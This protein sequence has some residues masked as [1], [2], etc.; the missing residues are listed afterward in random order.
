[1]PQ[2]KYTSDSTDSEVSSLALVKTQEL[3]ML[4][5]ALDYARSHVPVVPTIHKATVVAG[6][7]HAATIDEEQIR[8]W[9]TKFPTAEIAAPTGE[10]T[11]W[12]VVDVDA[13]DGGLQTLA[14]WEARHGPILTRTALTAHGGKHLYF[15]RPCFAVRNSAKSLGTGVDVRGDG[16]YTVLPGSMLPDGGRYVWQDPD[17]GI[18]DIPEWLATKLQN[19]SRPKSP[20][21]GAARGPITQGSRNPDLTSYLGRYVRLGIDR[22]A[23][24]IQALKRNAE[25]VPPLETSEVEKTVES[26]LRYDPED[27]LLTLPCTDAGASERMFELFGDRV[28]WIADEETWTMYADAAGRYV[29]DTTLEIDRRDRSDGLG[30][31]TAD[32]DCGG[33]DSQWNDQ[34]PNYERLRRLP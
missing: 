20:R 16:G 23:L 8:Q 32:A 12:I 29:D 34:P 24:L 10:K 33:K 2:D 31:S 26:V 3:S 17:A 27:P 30:D 1:M 21:S 19:I 11:G 18:A 15:T 13:E 9:W 7:L 4:E 25:Y 6:G 22:D 28:R 14:Q 5:I